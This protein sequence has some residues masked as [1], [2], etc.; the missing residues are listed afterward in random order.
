AW[1][2]PV[3]L[4]QMDTM[5]KSFWIADLDV[6]PLQIWLGVYPYPR[7]AKPLMGAL[8]LAGLVILYRQRPTWGALSIFLLVGQ[9]ALLLLL[10]LYRPAFIPRALMWPTIMYLV[11][12]AV[13]L[14]KIR[15]LAALAIAVALLSGIQMYSA[16]G[17]YSLEPQASTVETFAGDFDFEPQ[18]DVVVIAPQNLDWDYQYTTRDRESPRVVGLNYGDVRP[19]LAGWMLS[20]TIDRDSL[21][22]EVRAHHRLWVLRETSPMLPIARED[23]FDVAFNSLEDEYR[24]A[25]EVTSETHRLTR[26]ERRTP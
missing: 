14:S 5:M 10:S 12:L 26:Y 17:D 2:V 22:D 7:L 16:A 18:T 1:W 8:G 11:L 9:P 13:V 24:V 15:N 23:N 3:L 19:L 25:E 21:L 4:G 6:S 20:Q